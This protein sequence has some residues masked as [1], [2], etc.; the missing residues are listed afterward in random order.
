MNANVAECMGIYGV[1]V[2]M[3]HGTVYGDTF[4]TRNVLSMAGGASSGFTL[5]LNQTV[6]KS[7][8]CRFRG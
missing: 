6:T 1:L 3:E 8:V 4:A 2:A 7:C 5:L